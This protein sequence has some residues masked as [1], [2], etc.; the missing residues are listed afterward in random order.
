MAVNYGRDC[1]AD[2]ANVGMLAA[3]GDIIIWNEDDL[4]APEG[5]DA[6]I[7]SLVPDASELLTLHSSTGYPRDGVLFIPNCYTRA[8]RDALGPIDPAY[9][10]MY[11]DNEY[12]ERQKKL[13]RIVETGLVFDHRHPS[14][15]KGVTDSVYA[16]ENRPEAYSVGRLVLERRRAA[17]FPRVSLPG[18]PDPRPAAPAL[19]PAPVGPEP[20]HIT[21]CLPGETFRFEWLRGLVDLCASV[22]EAGWQIKLL[23]SYS[24]SVYLT[25]GNLTRA[26]IAAAETVRPEYVFWLDDDNIV[27][28]ADFLAMLRF[29]DENR[30]T[31]DILAGWCWIRKPDRWE[32]SLGDF[33]ADGVNLRPFDLRELCAGGL[34]PKRIEY[35]GFP[36]V[37]M[38]FG[39]LESL[40]SD[41][42]RPATVADLPDLLSGVAV[43]ASPEPHWF[44]G[45]DVGFSL[46]ARRAGLRMW[47]DPAAK[48]AHLKV[49]SAE[50]D[51]AIFQDT[52]EELK[53]WR[54]QV[55]GPAV[56]SPDVEGVLI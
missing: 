38:R 45:E 39:V 43:S 17:G 7:S 23:F 13:G 54:E 16:L 10:S 40:G 47:V 6:R 46:R 20:R 14:L 24:T 22:G 15:G 4:F 35:T 50:P 9:E 3:S 12:A 30:E 1:L 36:G 8:I 28:P 48:L 53:R 52:P 2:Q 19:E 33:S 42:F 56:A 37:L 49:Q 41:C 18:W 27:K 21:F 34:H 5:W 51:I 31:A 32:T 26:A 11:I 44:S 29:M 55:N 25:R